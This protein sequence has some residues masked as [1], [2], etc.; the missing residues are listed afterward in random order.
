MADDFDAFLS[1]ALA[2]PDG[3][4]DRA[5]V[6]RVQAQIR[7]DAHL[8]AERG[9][10]LKLLALQ[11]LGVA[12]LAAGGFWIS[13]SPAVAGFA[14]E[15]PAILLTV[16]LAVFSFVILLFSER[17]GLAEAADKQTKSFQ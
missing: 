2:P 15:S 7:L 4:A 9:G 16:L 1:E 3:E 14:G 17:T 10:V 13:R 5:F 12:A 11:V 6:R 8:R